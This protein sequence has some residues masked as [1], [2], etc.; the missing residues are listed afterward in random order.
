MRRARVVMLPRYKRGA[1]AHEEE[2][3]RLERQLHQLKSGA[4][5]A[6]ARGGGSPGTLPEIGQASNAG[7]FQLKLDG[8]RPSTTPANAA[9]GRSPRRMIPETLGGA[10]NR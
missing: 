8:G 1:A 6:R 3:A 4:A 9:R 5:S 7:G 10:D 2:A